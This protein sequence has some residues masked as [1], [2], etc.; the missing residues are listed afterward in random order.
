MTDIINY[1]SKRNV[2]NMEIRDVMSYDTI[3]YRASLLYYRWKIF[4]WFFRHPD[5]AKKYRMMEIYRMRKAWDKSWQKKSGY[6]DEVNKF[7]S[8]L[9]EKDRGISIA[10]PCITLSNSEYTVYWIL[11]KGI[12]DRNRW[13]RKAVIHVAP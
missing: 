11:I 1:P 5:V 2:I 9:T 13:T 6:P 4:R 3:V 10:C 8:S 12:A 7:I